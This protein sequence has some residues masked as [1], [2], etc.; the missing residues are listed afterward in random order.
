MGEH[1]SYMYSKECEKRITEPSFN[2]LTTIYS[3]YLTL[4]QQ[5]GTEKNYHTDKNQTVQC[6]PL[7]KS[8]NVMMHSLSIVIVSNNTRVE[9]I[10]RKYMIV[11]NECPM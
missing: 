4:S 11:P 10:K 9:E 1:L 2:N 7:R 5:S 8:L 3:R 6:F